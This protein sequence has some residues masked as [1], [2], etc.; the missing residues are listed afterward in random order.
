MQSKFNVE[1]MS[2]PSC[3]SKIE[4]LLKSQKGIEDVDLNFTTGK[5]KVDYNPNVITK[6]D[7]KKI[8]NKIGYYA[9]EA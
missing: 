8:I 6:K 7:I 2:C 3:A 5:M 4:I 9:E 1:G